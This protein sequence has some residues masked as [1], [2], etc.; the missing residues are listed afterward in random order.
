MKEQIRKEFEE[1]K[2]EGGF[3]KG[4]WK[5]RATYRDFTACDVP[6]FMGDLNPIISTRWITTVEGA[7]RTSE[8]EDKNKVNFATNFLRDSAKIW[9]DG[10]NTLAMK[11]LRLTKFQRMLKDEIREVISPFKCTTLEDLFWRARIKEADLNRKKSNKKKELKRKQDQS[12][13]F[14]KKARFDHVK[15]GNVGRIVS[16]CNRCGKNHVGIY[17]S[18][19]KGCFKCGDPNHKSNTCTKPVITCYTCNEIGNKS[20]ECPKE[21]AIEAIPI[22][23]IKEGKVEAPKAKARAYP[24]TAEEA[25]S[26]PDVITGIILVNSLPAQVLY[27]LG[28]SVSFVSYGFS[29]KLSTPLNKLPRTLEVEIAD[30]VG[31][32]WLSK[33][34]ATILCSQ[35]IIRVVN[36]SGRE[37]I[38]YGEKRKGELVLCSVM[39]ARKYLSRGC[40]AFLAHV[41]DT[42][43]EKNNT[44]NV[45]VVNEFKDVFLEDF[46]GISPE[47]QVEFCIDLTP[48]ATPIAKTPYHL[49]SF[50]MQELISQ[51][52][53]L[54]DKG[55]IRPSSSPWGA[56]I[57]FVKKKDG[58][59]RMCIDYR[60]LNIVTVREE[61]IPNTAF[62]TCYGHY[63]FVVM[64]FGLTNAPAIFM[65]LMNRVCRPMLDKSVI[66]FINDILIYSKSKEDHKL[67][68]VQFLGHVINP[69]GLKVNLSKI[70][71][72]MKWQAPKSV[73]E[74]QSFLGLAGYYRRFIQD[75]YK[76]AFSLTKLTKKNTP[77]VWGKEQDVAFCTLRK[78]LCEALILVLPE[79]TKDMVVYSDASYSSLG[80]VLMQ[81]DDSRGI[82]TQFGRVYIPFRSDIKDLLLEEAQ[83]SKYSIHP[84]AIKMYLDLKRN[85]WWP[86]NWDDHLPLVEFAYNNNYQDSIKMPPYEMLYGRKCRTPVC[87][88]EVG[89]RELASTDIVLATTEKIETIR[90]R[91]RAAQD[92]WKSY[93]D[94]RRRPIKFEVGDY[95]MLKVSPWKGLLRCKNKGK[96][97]L[98]FIGPFKILKRVGEPD[99]TSVVT[100]DDIEVDPELT[101]QEEP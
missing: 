1:L 80:C 2:K 8:C 68:E 26:L 75:F 15:T 55:F 33:Y 87:W 22:R 50:E 65:D 10:K 48:G 72:V 84:G 34:N 91:L 97:S 46:L 39:K 66:V 19:M 69:E 30:L 86:G 11:S 4:S 88:E 17:R 25:Q 74:I 40:H 96:L 47:R 12:E 57:L 42:S 89:R 16:R 62:R 100:L 45:P 94:N 18:G 77:F 79:G 54:F 53:E 60:E 82:K 81:R 99:E 59:M 6:K 43:F 49:A 35:K 83:K 38:I 23:S 63:E 67:Q 58:S 51:L 71:A 14:G 13:S 24:M 73:S 21:K 52:Q 95:V 20:N 36:P 27:D 44:D 5:D 37:I 32:D 70:E 31:M 64:P 7:F 41:I 101:S 61:D 9:W 29:E 98:I 85:Y 93:A 3:M 76:I 92:R 78:K 56:L 28:A 90:E